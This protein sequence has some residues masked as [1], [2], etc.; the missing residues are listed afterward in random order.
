[1]IISHKKKFVFLRTGKTASSSIEVYLS[2]FCSKEDTITPLGTFATDDE[3]KFKSRNGLP[4]SQNYILKK[5]SFGIKNFLNFNFYNNIHL[6]SHDP[7]DK[8]LKSEIG[9]NIKDYFFFCFIRNPF[10]WIVRS[11]W[12]HIYLKNKRDINWIN[13]L[14]SNEINKM[15]RNFLEE[16]SYDYFEKQKK[17]ASNKSIDI[18]VYKYENLN[19]NINSIKMK[20][21]IY[22]EKIPLKV[23]RFKKLNLNREIFID[24]NDEKLI[25]KNGEFFFQNYYKDPI[26][27]SKYKK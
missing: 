6:N 9:N 22:E 23:I 19:Q 13:N 7:I 1:M 10:D 12:W 11:F 21:N 18:N 17:I 20:L 8:V 3:D 24:E 2:Q 15:F 25:I 26:I 27:P 4:G 16:D 5:R 14:Q